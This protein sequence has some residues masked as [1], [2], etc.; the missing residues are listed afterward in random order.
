MK[1]EPGDNESSLDFKNAFSIEDELNAT[2]K[3][4]TVFNTES[5]VSRNTLERRVEI[6]GLMKPIKFDKVDFEVPVIPI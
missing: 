1:P 4:S 3:S 5:F 2:V 6:T